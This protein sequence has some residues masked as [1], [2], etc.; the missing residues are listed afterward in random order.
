[1]KQ[2]ELSHQL[3]AAEEELRRECDKRQRAETKAEEHRERARDIARE[4]D[5]ERRL[6]A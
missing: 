3:Q 1:L 5:E 2:E 4:M 6:A